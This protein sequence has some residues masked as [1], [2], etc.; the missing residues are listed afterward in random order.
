MTTSWDKISL[1]QHLQSHCSLTQESQ[2]KAIINSSYLMIGCL[3]TRVGKISLT[4]NE[5]CIFQY[6]SFSLV[7]L[8][9]PFHINTNWLQELRNIFST[10]WHHLLNVHLIAYSNK[11]FLW[12]IWNR[13]KLQC[14][15]VSKCRKRWKT[16]YC[17]HR[18]S[19][20]VHKSVAILIPICC[21]Y[22]VFLCNTTVSIPQII[23]S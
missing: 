19:E 8:L 15:K 4:S 9:E 14:K 21:V 16:Y 7:V 13:N 10:G 2:Q 12:A 23:R 17:Q 3:T 20:K 11:Y 6:P 18:L 22:S 5:C 1:L